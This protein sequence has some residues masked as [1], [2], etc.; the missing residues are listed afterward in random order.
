[1]AQPSP[2]GG[3]LPGMPT[4]KK[5]RTGLWVGLGCGC[6]ALLALIVGGII[7]AFALMSG[8]DSKESGGGDTTTSSEASDPK[9]KNNEQSDPA[10]APPNDGDGDSQS[11]NP[12]PAP[13]PEPHDGAS[14]V[15]ARGGEPQKV[16]DAVLVNSGEPHQAPQNFDFHSIYQMPD[17]TQI[18]VGVGKNTDRNAESVAKTLP[19]PQKIGKWTCAVEESSSL[20]GCITQDATHGYVAI[21]AKTLAP[22]ELAA[23]GDELLG[24]L[25]EQQ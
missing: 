25:N 21:G 3:P 22:N 14:P 19:N 13:V 24:A 16:G 1:M 8:D 15:E 23:W 12:A 9:P 5:S 6:I 4:A 2:Y 7:L 17:G 10:P 20:T 18:E 11:P